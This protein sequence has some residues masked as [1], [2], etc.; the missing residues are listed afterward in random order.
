MRL[1]LSETSHERAYLP[2]SKGPDTQGCW[3]VGTK[4][5]YLTQTTGTKVAALRPGEASTRL[6]YRFLKCMSRGSYGRQ[7]R[8]DRLRGSILETGDRTFTLFWYRL[9]PG[10]WVFLFHPK[11]GAKDRKDK[12]RARK[13]GVKDCPRSPFLYEMTWLAIKYLPV[14]LNACWLNCV[15]SINQCHRLITFLASSLLSLRSE[16]TGLLIKEIFPIH[17]IIYLKDSISELIIS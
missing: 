7:A 6:P 10:V 12:T 2:R 17:Y 14:C 11:R 4:L 9:G 16:M 3:T 13:K 1:L 15:P 5:S 8:K